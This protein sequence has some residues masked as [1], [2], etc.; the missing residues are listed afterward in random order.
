MSLKDK[1]AIVTG[2][3]SGIGRAIVLALA[4][5]GANVVIDYVVDPDAT[6]ALEREIADLGDQCISV[7]A[8]VSR[9]ADL[10]K[11]VDAVVAKFG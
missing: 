6:E 3:N 7:E 1:A 9:I 8:D 4:R 11:L 2:G 10:Q 5:E